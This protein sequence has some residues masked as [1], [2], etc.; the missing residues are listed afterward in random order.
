MAARELAALI[1]AAGKG[2]RLNSRRPKVLHEVGGRPMLGFALEAVQA[3][4]AQ[5][6]LVVVGYGA[7]A[8]EERFEGRAEF[9]L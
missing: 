6:C 7:E 3:L 4:G 1:L 2:T 5:R 8:V 9:V